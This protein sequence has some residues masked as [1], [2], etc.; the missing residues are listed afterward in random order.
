MELPWTWLFATSEARIPR[1]DNFA[2]NGQ[3]S[4]GVYLESEYVVLNEPLWEQI[5]SLQPDSGTLSC[6]IPIASWC[7]R[8]L[9][10]TIRA[11]PHP[12]RSPQDSQG[13]LWMHKKLT[14]TDLYTVQHNVSQHYSTTGSIGQIDHYH[15]TRKLK[16]F[17]TGTVRTTGTAH[18]NTHVYS[19]SIKNILDSGFPSPY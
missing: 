8:V 11:G 16:A 15:N 7:R 19:Y 10:G 5:W 18:K 9:C 12:R 4:F 1:R 6:R 17:C 13:W 3:E 2:I 14:V